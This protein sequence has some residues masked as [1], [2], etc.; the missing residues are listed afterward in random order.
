MIK[1]VCQRWQIGSLCILGRLGVQTPLGGGKVAGPRPPSPLLGRFQNGKSFPLAHSARKPS[2]SFFSFFGHCTFFWCFDVFCMH[3]LQ[4][5]QRITIL[6][7][8]PKKIEDFSPILSWHPSLCRSTKPKY[9]FPSIPRGNWSR[10]FFASPRCQ[11]VIPLSSPPRPPTRVSG[12][13]PGRGSILAGCLSPSGPPLARGPS[14]RGCGGRAGPP[15]RAVPWAAAGPSQ[16]CA[17]LHRPHLQESGRSLSQPGRASP[18][19]RPT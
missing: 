10:H 11:C 6:G 2:F 5:Y 19:R 8:F 9:S 13:P 18:V 15:A 1:D 12:K 16:G 17:A 3:S 7:F 4:N 14:R